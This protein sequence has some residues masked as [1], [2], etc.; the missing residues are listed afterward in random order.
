MPSRKLSVIVPAY[1]EEDTIV[2]AVR[3]AIDADVKV[4]IDGRSERVEKEI[5]VVDDASTDAT[6]ER[7]GDLESNQ[8]VILKHARN[9]GKGAAI[10]T[11]LERAT[12]DVVIIHDAD[13][14]YDP[15]DFG[16]LVEPIFAGQAEVVYGTRFRGGRPPGM[17]LSNWVANRILRGVAN[18]LFGGRISDEAT[19]YKALRRDLTSSLGLSCE[20]FEFCP[21]VTA[22]LLRRGIAIGEVPIS[23][24]ARGARS[25]KKIGYKD[26]LEAVWTLVKY[27][28]V[29]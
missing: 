12:G 23:Y 29:K 17:R 16:K 13:L 9:R 6:L 24:K 22:K 5:I 27:R 2:E 4:R 11:A 18:L 8:V 14:E 21:E 15:N 10:R 28:F 1:N 19:C 7:L 25:G 26:A 3:R 20:R